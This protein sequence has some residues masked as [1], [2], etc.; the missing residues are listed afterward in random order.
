MLHGQ[1]A[2]ETGL[3]VV[4][5]DQYGEVRSDV[6]VEGG[7]VLFRM[8]VVMGSAEDLI[9]LV[10]DHILG[11]DDTNVDVREISGC[12]FVETGKIFDFDVSARQEM[13]NF[14]SCHRDG[15]STCDT[16]HDRRAAFW[17]TMLTDTFTSDA[18][19]LASDSERTIL[20]GE[21]HIQEGSGEATCHQGETESVE[22]I[23]DT[24]V[25]GLRTELDDAAVRTEDTLVIEKADI[26]FDDGIEE[27]HVV[28]L[29]LDCVR[30]K[31][32]GAIRKEELT[33]NFLDGKNS[34]SCRQV[35][36]DFSTS[37]DI[38]LVSETTSRGRLNDNFVNL[39]ELEK[40]SD[41]VR[42]EGSTTFPNI[43]V[44]AANGNNSVTTQITSINSER[45]TKHFFLF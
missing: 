19:G 11:L 5:S 17:E 44:F 18:D 6:L 42:N 25:T 36:V 15:T 22:C 39:F 31:H 4:T 37:F 16:E 33:G 21:G 10:S 23:D 9:V 29:S 8:S 14:L 38:F 12:L 2:R 35:F 20:A 45:T 28:G 24:G 32:V 43:F 3:P 34:T 26:G 1:E 7:F 41:L 13:E 30:E 40:I 27:G